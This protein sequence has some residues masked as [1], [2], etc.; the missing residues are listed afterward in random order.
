ML[1]EVRLLERSRE[2]DCARSALR[3]ALS[4]EGGVLM[5]EGTRGLGKTSLLR[6][7]RGEAAAQ[8]F[9]V[10]HARGNELE[11]SFPWAVV[12]QLFERSL[13]VDHAGADVGAPLSGPATLISALFDY[14][15]SDSPRTLASGSDELYSIVH[16]LYWLCCNF[17]AQQPLLLVIDDVQWADSCSL[18]F[19][20]YLVNRLEGESILVA[21][22]QA[23]DRIEDEVTQDLV[24]AACATPLATVARLAPLSADAVREVITTA[25]GYSPHD[26]VLHV[27]MAITEGNPLHLTELVKEMAARGMKPV[28]SSVPRIRLLAP[29]RLTWDIRRHIS[30]LPEDAVALAGAVAVLD[31]RAEPRYSAVV[32]GL[33][34]REVS[35]AAGCLRDAGILRTGVPYAFWSPIAR[36]VIYADMAARDR[37][38]AHR[39]AAAA[40]QA[41]EAE[42]ATVAEHLCRTDPG[43]LPWAVDVL[44]SAARQAIAE[45]HPYTAVR[46]LRRALAESPSAPACARLLAELG[47]AELRA[48]DRSAVEHLVEALRRA[49]E[50]EARQAVRPELALAFAASGRYREALETVRAGRD[51]EAPGADRAPGHVRTVEAVLMRMMRGGG[52]DR[53]GSTAARPDEAVRVHAA[54]EAWSRGRCVRRVL[55]LAG[56]AVSD[57]VRLP[58]RDTELPPASIVAWVLTQ[59]DDMPAAERVLTQVARQAS[60]AGHLLAA[61]TAESLRTRI[62]LDTGRL[63]EAEAAAT[64]VLRDH[65]ATSLTPISTPVA[66]ATLVHCMIE[67]GRADEAEEFLVALG[68]GRKL[69]DAAPFVPLRIARGRLRIRLDRPDDGLR[70]LIECRELALSEGW[71]YP[72]SVSEYLGDAV[73]AMA[74]ERSARDARALAHEELERCRV[75][76]A[77]RPL[78]VALRALAALAGGPRGVTRLEEADRLLAGLPDM[79]ERARTLVEL[80]SALRRAGNRTEARQQLTAGMELAHR[81]GASS[82]EG[83]ARSELRLAGTRL[84]KV[85][86]GPSTV[87]TPAETRV[88][89][90]AAGGLSNKEISQALYVTV[91]TVEWHL[92]QVYAK[93][94]IAKRSELPQVLAAGSGA[95]LVRYGT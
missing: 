86:D 80:G 9:K 41:V 51:E 40:L 6:S 53:R 19:I 90:K 28:E 81:I 4:G 17:S 2:F 95:R 55:R 15:R 54:V 50:P 46:Y 11:R 13:A 31:A 71:L 77:A 7:L 65:H 75:F 25:L 22:A 68:F 83:V 91:K 3:R 84:A 64:A 26:A 76:G 37:G 27:C 49:Q 36:H 57:D 42:P 8:G 33:E 67:T 88:A 18:H 93:L 10:L 85:S 56:S 21:L 74:V 45:G 20:S 1:R 63:S 24:V 87:L 69:P 92:G 66:A 73:R 34:E 70:E 89:E 78:A 60:G 29:A 44:S 14:D 23:P 30:Q 94:G 72:S 38:A 47:S 43:A 59:C 48:Q 12:R 39:R 35:E 62:L 52:N 5:F 32:A 61:T 82:V 16:G 79:L 58:G